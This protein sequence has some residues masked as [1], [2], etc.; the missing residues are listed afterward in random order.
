MPS[1]FPRLQRLTD[2]QLARLLDDDVAF[3]VFVA[4]EEGDVDMKKMQ[5]TISANNVK[6]ARENL[7]REAGLSKLHKD[8]NALQDELQLE[9]QKYEESLGT[10]QK[11]TH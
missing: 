7:S 11:T 9:M 5:Q 2:V 4:E 10:L 1:E 3:E 8:V 6:I